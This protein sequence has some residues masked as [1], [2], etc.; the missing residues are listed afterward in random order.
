[1]RNTN[2]D[3]QPI[4]VGL[5]GLGRSGWNIH[6]AVMSTLAD[7]YRIVAVT[8]PDQQRCLEAQQKF[9][10]RTYESV[11]AM[12]EDPA[13]ELMVVATPNHLHAGNAIAALRAGKHVVIEK[14]V[15]CH[16]EELDAMIDAA[17]RAERMLVPFQN[18]RYDPHFQK[19]RS[20]IQ[21]GV[22]GR[23]VQIRMAWH[24]FNRRWDWQTLSEFGGGT[25]N[26]AGPHFLDQALQLF[27]P[28]EPQVFCH[29]DS[30]LTLGDT[31]DHVLMILR[32]PGA[33]LIQL[34]ITSVC[35]LPQ[36]FWL[37]MGDRG[38][39]RGTTEHLQWQVTDFNQQPPRQIHR[40]AAEQ[41]QYNRETLIWTRNEWTVPEQQKS[42]QWTRQRFYED[43]YETL[44]H[45]RPPIVLPQQV[46]RQISILEQAR[47][48]ACVS[49]H[50]TDLAP[51]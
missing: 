41:R 9:G 18:R 28:A 12:L 3:E 24:M 26:N 27:G 38:T 25:L 11:S 1:M 44:R 19:V 14:P 46:R 29:L 37:V 20:I 48:Q 5:A 39:L 21:S 2:Q 34:E 31:D 10:S 7:R 15:A 43:M 30:A 45:G 13:I 42:I 35:S 8:D 22:L 51:A 33:P 40:G 32:A 49:G 36:D 16:L 6:A 47:R 23:I 4:A 50:G 17:Q